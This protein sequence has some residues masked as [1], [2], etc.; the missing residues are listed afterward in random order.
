[1][2]ACAN[3]FHWDFSFHIHLYKSRGNT[4]SAEDWGQEEIKTQICIL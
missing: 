4:E 1:M 3:I 2:H